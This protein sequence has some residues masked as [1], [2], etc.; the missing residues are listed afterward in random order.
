VLR[1]HLDGYKNRNH[2]EA[3]PTKTLIAIAGSLAPSQLRPA[4]ITEAVARLNNPRYAITTRNAHTIVLRRLLRWLWD[5]HGAPK[6]DRLVPTLTPARPRNVTATRSEIDTLI[7]NA[8]P[9]LRALLILCSDLAIRSGTAIKIAPEH[10]NAERQTLSFT[11]KKDAHVTLAITQAVRDLIDGCDL[12]NPLPFIT[13]KRREE[14]FRARYMKRPWMEVSILH[15]ELKDLRQR[16]GITKRIIFHDLRRSAAVATLRYT[17]NLRT[18]Q[19]L[20]GHRSL[21]STIWYL[22]HDLYPVDTETLEAI[23]QPHLVWKKGPR[24]A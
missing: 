12:S 19:S 13:Q 2:S 15:K 22:D 11:T 18:V 17:N 5:T 3:T 9:A 6:Y 4:H 8:T 14:C 10:Y 1:A 23:K 16:L 21:Q 20:L 7:D 24:T